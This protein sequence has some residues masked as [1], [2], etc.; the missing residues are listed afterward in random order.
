MSKNAVLRTAPTF[1]APIGGEP[2]QILQGS[3]AS[4]KLRVC[5]LLWALFL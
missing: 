5:G 1:I 4:E 3:L 2:V